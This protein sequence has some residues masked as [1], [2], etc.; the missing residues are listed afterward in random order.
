[1]REILLTFIIVAGIYTLG[2][3]FKQ[4]MNSNLSNTEEYVMI[5]D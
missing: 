4:I 2:F 5:G 1:M 3:G